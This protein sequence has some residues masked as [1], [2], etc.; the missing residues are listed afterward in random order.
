M[1]VQDGEVMVSGR[2][3][4]PDGWDKM[5]VK[6]RFEDGGYPLIR[7]DVEGR[8]AAR[9]LRAAILN[10]NA[11]YAETSGTIHVII[12]F[13]H[14]GSLPVNLLP[15]AFELETLNISTPFTHTFVIKPHGYIDAI[16]QMAR[17][18]TPRLARNVHVV[19]DVSSAL[20]MIAG[21]HAPTGTG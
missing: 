1:R 2:S 6:Y 4:V 11:Y 10:C 20:D 18:V 13:T 12:D 9:D 15:L 8:W 14:S 17:K 19:A 7:I 16:I 5:A 21:L 3:A